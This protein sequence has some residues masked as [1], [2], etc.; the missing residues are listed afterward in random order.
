MT[1][2]LDIFPPVSIPGDSH[3]HPWFSVNVDLP[4]AVSA[5]YQH[6]ANVDGSGSQTI[7]IH[8]ALYLY[9]ASEMTEEEQHQELVAEIKKGL[10]SGPGTEV[11]EQFWIKFKQDCYTRHEKLRELERA[12]KMGNLSLPE[13]LYNFVVMKIRSGIHKNPTEVVI[14]ALPFLR[15]AATK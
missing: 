11:N 3:L 2:N 10:D 7:N 13:E 9:R 1:D 15:S 6:F 14:A 12:G 4:E 8:G 5:E